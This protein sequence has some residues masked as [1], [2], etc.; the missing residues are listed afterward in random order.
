MTDSQSTG[1]SACSTGGPCLSKMKCTPCMAIFM[2]VIIIA[3]LKFAG[4]F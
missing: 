3:A 1:G 2:A 4:V